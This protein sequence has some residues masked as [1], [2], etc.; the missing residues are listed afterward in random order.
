[1]PL[2]LYLCRF[3]F[4]NFSSALA[5]HAPL[6]CRRA[7]RE[8]DEEVRHVVLRSGAHHI[9]YRLPHY[10]LCCILY[11]I[12]LFTA[13]CATYYTL[14]CIMYYIIM[15]EGAQQSRLARA[16]LPEEDGR[17]RRPGVRLGQRRRCHL[18]ALCSY[19]LMLSDVVIVLFCLVCVIV[20][21]YVFIS[22]FSLSLPPGHSSAW[23]R[24]RPPA[25]APPSGA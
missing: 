24:R 8:K 15:A 20:C 19:V 5:S 23:P 22:C 7:P 17:G 3:S 18:G 6:A 4:E 16:G 9:R 2:Y 12:P 10:M 21:W 25:W 13:H 14:Y 11:S 1:M